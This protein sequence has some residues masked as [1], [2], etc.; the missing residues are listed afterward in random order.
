MFCFRLQLDF[1]PFQR[2]IT[3]KIRPFEAIFTLQNV[4]DNGCKMVTSDCLTCLRTVSDHQKI[5]LGF[6][7]N[8]CIRI[9]FHIKCRPKL[10]MGKNKQTLYSH[11]FCFFFSI[12]KYKILIICVV[13]GLI[14]IARLF[15]MTAPN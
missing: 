13:H 12:E 2:L 14:S 6:S 7:L 10:N 8:A 3:A 9:N 4:K 1:L 5:V 15:A 11:F